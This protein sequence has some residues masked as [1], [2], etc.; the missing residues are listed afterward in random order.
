VA[1]YIENVFRPTKNFSITPG[2]R[3]EY[4]N[5]TAK[6]YI[7]SEDGYQ[8]NSDRSRN[9][10][11]PLAGI[12]LQYKTTGTTELY[13]NWSQAYRP[14]DYSQL[15]PI[16]TTSVIDPNLKDAS[17]F[18]S[19]LGYR[20]TVRNYLSFDI[21][22]FYMQ[23]NNRIGLVEK[24]DGNGNTYTYRTNV[25]NSRHA[26]LETYIEFNPVKAFVAN[27]KHGTLS[28]FNS[29]SFIDA[30][31]TSGQYKNNFVENAPR[32]IDRFGVTYAVEG[33][34]AT[35]LTSYTSA[36]FSDADNT[37]KS[38]DAVIGQVPA[39]YVFDLS[40]S[41]K[42]LK[43]FNIK[44]GIN[45]LADKRYYTKRTDEYPGPGIIP[46]Q[47]RSFYVGIGARF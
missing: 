11:I 2:F 36:C 15:T 12:G 45:N 3:F 34:S 5:S 28:F 42:F 40:A 38:T 4:I 39:Y 20:G 8:I 22:G 33:F 18:N 17:G 13:G 24:T 23:Y 7:T 44:A 6:G 37:V 29:F 14:T 31:Y 30:R 9:R 19:D 41:Y 16:G 10:Y 47:G 46:A 26:G 32:F 1:P 27:S 35:F 43:R 21:S 25:A